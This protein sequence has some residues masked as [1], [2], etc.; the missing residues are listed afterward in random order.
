MATPFAA[1]APLLG[2]ILVTRC[3]VAPEHIE[4]ALAKQREEGGLIGEVLL[5][6]KLIDADQLALALAVQF[7]MGYL[8]ELPRADD[9]P[10]DLIDKLPINFARQREV[11]PLRRD[12]GRVVIAVADP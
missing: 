4:R 8:R 5:R 9:I 11:L 12:N 1:H 10:V 7:D 3:K 6:L 2:E